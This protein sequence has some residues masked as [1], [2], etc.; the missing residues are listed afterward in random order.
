MRTALIGYTGFV[1]G[2]L[3]RQFAFDKCYRSVD[4]EL[5]AAEQFDLV[6]C[7]GARAEKW[8]ANADP[9]SDKANINRLQTALRTASIGELI[10]IST[11]YVYRH[12]VG[13]DETTPVE[14]D[15]L[16]A[17]GLHRFQLEQFCRDHFQTR[18]FR[19]P[20]LFGSGL[21][22]NAIY[23]L[24]HGN[25]VEKIHSLAQYQ[26]YDLERLWSDIDLARRA[27]LSLVNLAT[28]PLSMQDVARSAFGLTFRI[29][30]DGVKPAQYDM[31]TVH[32]SVFGASQ[33]LGIGMAAAAHDSAQGGLESQ[34]ICTRQDLLSRLS[35]F[36]SR[37]RRLTA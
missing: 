17:Y 23:D 9:A 35:D 28:P 34:Y 19:L 4:I 3:Q 29:Q 25:Q 12:P 6:V 8:K 16:G 33:P 11:V 14:T 1:G 32:A 15:G 7:C 30:P 31:R 37:Q 36:V 26:F 2:N 18:V 13:V 5:L 10:L 27:D 24:L 20:G 21:K 22:K